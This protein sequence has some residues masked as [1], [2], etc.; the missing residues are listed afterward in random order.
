MQ[1]DGMMYN[2]FYVQELRKKLDAFFGLV[3]RNWRDSIPKAIGFFLV[4][5]L[6]DKMLRGEKTPFTEV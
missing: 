4:R 5:A 6:E 2:K 1:N 3:I